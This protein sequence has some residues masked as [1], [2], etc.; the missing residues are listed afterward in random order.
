MLGELINL[1]HG[2]EGESPVFRNER[3]NPIDHDNF[4]DRRFDKDVKEWGGRR[5]RFHDLRHTATTL[6]IAA[7]IDIRT[8]KEI[9][10]HSDI[11]TT[12]NYIHLVPGQI[13]KVAEC[14]SVAP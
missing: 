9:C 2:Q 6:L 5:I 13:E 1:I 12:M 4:V 3:G 10:G 11:K 14:F 8:V 7:G